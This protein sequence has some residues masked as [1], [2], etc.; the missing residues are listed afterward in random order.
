MLE[1]AFPGFPFCAEALSAFAY[2]EDIFIVTTKDGALHT[3]RPDHPAR[4]K[5][6]L[7]AYRVRNV[8]TNEPAAPAPYC[9]QQDISRFRQLGVWNNLLHKIIIRER[10][11]Q[12]K[13]EFSS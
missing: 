11:G 3:F 7:D 4:F 10:E 12:G 2:C 9:G 13:P 8:K 5:R 1:N 6:W